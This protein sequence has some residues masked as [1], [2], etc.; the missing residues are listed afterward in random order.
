MTKIFLDL[1]LV[2]LAESAQSNRL[3]QRGKSLASLKASH[4]HF[5][6]AE[7]N[8][9]NAQFEL[10]SCSGGNSRRHGQN[11]TSSS[12]DKLVH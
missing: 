3:F 12:S 9:G 5:A 1:K 10:E 7:N 4:G 6:E 8:T 2:E 11:Q